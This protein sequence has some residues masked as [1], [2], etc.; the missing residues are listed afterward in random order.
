MR[1]MDDMWLMTLKEKTE[2][3]IETK[4]LLQGYDRH[5]KIEKEREGDKIQFLDREIIWDGKKL[6][7][8]SYN[9]N[10]KELLNTGSRKFQNLL[11]YE[12]YGDY[13]TKKGI[14]V[15]RFLRIHKSTT[16]KRDVFWKGWISLIEL[17]MLGYG[18]RIIEDCYIWCDMQVRSKIWRLLILCFSWWETIS[19]S[20][21]ST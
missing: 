17:R 8:Q 19:C 16:E 1:Y 3:W 11:H 20:R 15:S 4:K 12:S 5:L 13:K 7:E 18:R 10:F 2:K 6:K 14:I 21:P 9:K